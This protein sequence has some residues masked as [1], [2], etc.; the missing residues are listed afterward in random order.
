MCQLAQCLRAHVDG[1]GA[2]TLANAAKYASALPVI[3]LSAAKYHVAPRA[4][5]LY[6]KPLWVAAAAVN[7]AFSTYWDV[8]HDWELLRPA[9]VAAAAGTP[10]RRLQ[11]RPERLY[12]WRALYW[13]ALGSNAMLRVSWTYKL[14][15]H[16]R[17]NRGTVFVV[18]LLEAARR[19]Q[20]TFLRLEVAYL[21]RTRG[22]D[23]KGH[24]PPDGDAEAAAAGGQA[25]GTTTVV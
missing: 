24:G 15:A 10:R 13:G 21:R 2:T 23:G 22:A 18:A 9:P 3:S 1:G 12:A 8:V 25:G 7:S 6:Y 17:H 5:A 11:L 14:S 20:W 4:W 16:L 19:C